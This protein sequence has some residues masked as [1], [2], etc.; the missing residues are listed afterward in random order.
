MISK[1]RERKRIFMRAD[2]EQFFHGKCFPSILMKATDTT[3]ATL[4]IAAV[5][6]LFTITPVLVVGEYIEL[7]YSIN[8]R[9]RGSGGGN[10]NKSSPLFQDET[11]VKFSFCFLL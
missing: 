8:F 3:Q 2:D 1:E 11:D 10:N 9:S 4:C 5:R 7:W 6:T